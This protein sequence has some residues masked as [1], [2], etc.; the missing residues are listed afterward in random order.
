MK[1]CYEAF[2][3]I[4]FLISM[5]HTCMLFVWEASLGANIVGWLIVA[6]LFLIGRIFGMFKNENEETDLS[7][8]YAEK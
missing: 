7:D 5:L 6:V 1:S 3:G 2:V 4:L 8:E